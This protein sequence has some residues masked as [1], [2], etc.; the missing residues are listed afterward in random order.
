MRLLNP[1]I[2]DYSEINTSGLADQNA[3]QNSQRK[4]CARARLYPKSTREDQEPNGADGAH[5][6]IAYKH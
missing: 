1:F 6:Q 2:S 4:R 3:S 5:G